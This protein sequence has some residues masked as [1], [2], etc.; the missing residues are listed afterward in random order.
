[1]VLAP[2][3]GEPVVPVRSF[4]YFEL[5]RHCHGGLKLRHTLFHNHIRK[6]NLLRMSRILSVGSMA[7]RKSPRLAPLHTIVFGV[8]RG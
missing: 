2:M 4:S 1:M 8:N 7:S 3:E 5:V 6:K